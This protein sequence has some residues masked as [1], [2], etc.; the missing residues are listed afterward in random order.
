MPSKQPK[1]II[2]LPFEQ[3]LAFIE[4]CTIEQKQTIFERISKEV[5][6]QRLEKI[7][8]NVKKPYL[9]DEEIIDEVKKYRKEQKDAKPT[10]L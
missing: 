10:Q 4:Q 6:V 5:F 3:L 9:S 2:E 1:F 7:A 8:K